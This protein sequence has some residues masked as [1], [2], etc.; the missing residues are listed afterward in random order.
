MTASE[1]IE[2]VVRAGGTLR[3]EGDRIK[4]RFPKGAAHLV[5]ELKEHKPELI[6]LLRKAGGRIATFPHCPKCASYALFRE[7]NIGVYEC[8]TCGLRG[9]EEH[10]ARRLQ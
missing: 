7:N 6:E 3:L 9:I 1:L 5:D 4:Y 2:S 8:E 10:I